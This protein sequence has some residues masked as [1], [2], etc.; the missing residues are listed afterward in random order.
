MKKEKLFSVTA[1][2]CTWQYFR[3]SGPGGQKVNKT[4]TG[5]RCVHP[6]SGAVGK[7][8]D[9]R[10]RAQNKKLA[11][12]RMAQSKEFKAWVKLEC[13]R[14]AGIIDAAQRYADQEINSDRVVVE[15]KIDGKWTKKEEPEGSS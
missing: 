5:V 15:Y 4:E 14:R 10:S 12:K 9:T 3:C 2:D 1:K 13:A 6:P 7:A 8:Q 11:F